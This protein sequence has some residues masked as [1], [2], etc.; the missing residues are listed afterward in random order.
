[1][2]L[3]VVGMWLLF[4]ADVHCL[5]PEKVEF[6]ASG[7]R[8]VKARAQVHRSKGVISGCYN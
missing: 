7:L 8:D 1:M 4:K 2:C 5:P 6:R 3:V